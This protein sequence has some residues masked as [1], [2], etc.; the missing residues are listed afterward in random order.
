MQI[1]AAQ[2]PQ[3]ISTLSNAGQSTDVLFNRALAQVLNKEYDKAL[4]TLTEVTTANDQ[5]ALAYY[6]AAIAAARLKREDQLAAA[7]SK[8][9][10]LNADLRAKALQDLEFNAYANSEVFRNA[11]K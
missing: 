11:V 1:K 8:A 9:I 4:A 2:Y 3:A 7:V 6:V 5:D 10:S